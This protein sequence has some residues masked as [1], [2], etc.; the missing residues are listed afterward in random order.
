MR[1]TLATN[2]ELAGKIEALERK[3]GKHDAEL[4]AILSALRKLLEPPAAGAKRPIGFVPAGKGKKRERGF[5]ACAPTPAR[6]ALL[7]CN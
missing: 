3:V 1:Q 4:Q 5:A 7:W 6:E 2:R